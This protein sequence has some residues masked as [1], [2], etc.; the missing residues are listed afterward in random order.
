M[1]LGD[2]PD[3]DP[4]E[5]GEVLQPPNV[6][7]EV[8]PVALPSASRLAT[9]ASSRPRRPISNAVRPGVVAGSPASGWISSSINTS[10]RVTRPRGARA[11]VQTNSIGTSWSI[12]R[13]PCSAEAA[14]PAT[15]PP[16]WDHSHAALVRCRNVG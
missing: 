7:D 6:V 9:A 2:H 13:D 16:R 12:Q 1:V 15:T 8:K 11:L 5:L 10:R 3:D 14:R 4:P